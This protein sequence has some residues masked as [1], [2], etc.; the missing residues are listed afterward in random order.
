[1]RDG[2]S[3]ETQDLCK[4]FG[5]FVAVDN[6]NL[7]IN[8]GE[9]Y[10]FLGP[11]GAGKTTTLMMVLG[12]LRPSSGQVLINNVPNRKSNFDLKSKIGVVAEYQSFYE[13]MSAWEYLSFFG[14]LF[15]V[16][17]SKQRAEALMEQVGLWEWR[18]VLIGGYSTGMKKK[19][20]FVRAL[21]HQPEFLVLDEPVSG[22]DPYGIS[23]V[24]ELILKEKKDGCTLLISS[25][26]LSEVE[27]TVDR[28]GII[29]EGKLLVEDKMDALRTNFKATKVIKL[30]FVEI[31]DTFLSTINAKPYTMRVENT[32]NTLHITTASENDV[33]EDIGQCILDHKM[34]VLEIKQE[35]SSLEDAFIAITNKNLHSIKQHL[36]AN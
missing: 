11:N 33:L 28:V 32:D 25:H 24:R 31:K 3:L 7:R 14:Q 17:N 35:E 34:I 29:A 10:G 6:I 26:I 5:E 20:G 36:E 21:L 19:L 9:S 18:N 2:F 27:K 22:L 23:Q 12:V 8:P 16:I 30:R 13:E 15:N 1:M 4:K